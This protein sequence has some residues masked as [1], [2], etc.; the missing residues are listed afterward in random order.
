M[1]NSSLFVNLKKKL[2]KNLYKLRH[3][4]KKLEKKRNI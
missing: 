1:Y 3:F 2:L 4:N